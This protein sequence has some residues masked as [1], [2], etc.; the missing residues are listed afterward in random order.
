LT[1]TVFGT[2]SSAF[3]KTV[4]VLGGAH[5]TQKAFNNNIIMES[6]F[7]S[8]SSNSSTEHAPLLADIH[9]YGNSSYACIRSSNV[10]NTT[11]EAF[12]TT[13][14]TSTSTDYNK[15]TKKQKNRM[16]MMTQDS[17]LRLWFCCLVFSVMFTM[18]WCRGDSG[19][20]ELV[21]KHKDEGIENSTS[22]TACTG[23]DTC[24]FCL[25]NDGTHTH[26]SLHTMHRTC[27]V[28]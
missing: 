25:T 9:E 22:S 14:T 17:S 21:F 3:C 8:S 11:K 4:L 1:A 13:A 19:T 15:N 5:S 12:A 20:T 18:Y 26:T 7:C 2:G 28:Q 23:Y 16:M 24:T 27:N 10:C 6:L